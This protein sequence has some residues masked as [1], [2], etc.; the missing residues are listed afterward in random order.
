MPLC[1]RSAGGADGALCASVR[2]G[3]GEK[4]LSGVSPWRGGGISRLGSSAGSRSHPEDVRAG[5]EANATRLGSEDSGED[6]RGWFSRQGDAEEP[7][8]RV[9]MP[10]GA[11]SE[12]SGAPGLR[13]SEPFMMYPFSG[14]WDR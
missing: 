10:P 5:G 13:K 2:L 14:K 1:E 6:G 7:A 9:E 8:G 11:C 12:A 4:D 3:A